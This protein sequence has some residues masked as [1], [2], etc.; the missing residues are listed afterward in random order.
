M[1]LVSPFDLRM[2][3]SKGSTSQLLR[4]GLLAQSGLLVQWANQAAL[5][6]QVVTVCKDRL[7]AMVRTDFREALL[8][9]L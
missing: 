6:G 3:R 7:V 9:R 4:M 2:V 8:K 5:E 1:R